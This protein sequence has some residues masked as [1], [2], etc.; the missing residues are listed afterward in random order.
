MLQVLRTLVEHESPSRD[1]PALDLLAAGLAA[2]LAAIGAR[3]TVQANSR[4][5]D[6]VLGVFPG[7][8]ADAPPALLL[9]HFDTVWP[10][11]TLGEMPFRVVDG[12]AHGPGV[13]DMKA[14]LVQI[15]Y[16]I[17]A[18]QA[19]GPGMPRPLKVLW[20]SDEEIGSPTSRTLIEAEARGAAYAL[21]PEP[22][23]SGGVLKTARKGVGAFTVEVTGRAAHAGVEPEKGA[24]ATVELAHQILRIAALGDH[25]AGTTLNVGVIEGGTTGNVVAA[26]ALAQVDVRAWTAREAARVEAAL[27]S[28][29]PRTPGTSLRISGGF[30]RPPMERLEATAALFER[31]RAIAGGLDIALAE[32]S[33]GG[34]SDGNFTAAL[35]VATLDGLG[36]EGGGAHA[37]NEHIRV[38]SLPER[39]ELLAALLAAL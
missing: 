37:E 2:R 31:A 8:E 33:T 39:T 4:G 25:G 7:L 35:G 34:G 12:R 23:L 18:I 16:A 26:R 21:V 29:E 14:G 10:R 24:S 38:E 13:Y 17:R 27:R 11:G 9:G 30:N 32:G 19:V 36:C 28:L 15:E 1:K 6:H 5:G 22:P 3:V 20:T